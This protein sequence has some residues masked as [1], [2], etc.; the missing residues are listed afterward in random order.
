MRG[1]RIPRARY[2]LSVAAALALALAACGGDDSSSSDGATSAAADAA[3]TAAAAGESSAAAASG[4]KVNLT[5]W[6]WGD[7]DAP[8]ANGW[9][10]AAVTAY[11]AKNPN[12]T[13]EVVEQ[14]TDTFIATFQAAAAAKSGP[15]I[16][17]Q[18]ATG[19]VLTQ[20]WGGAVTAIS[21]LVPA[22]ETAHWL[23]TSENTYDG[24]V[25]A[26]PLYLIGIP[27]VSNKD[28][29][30][31]A[32]ITAPPATWDELISACTALRAKDITP[33]AFGNDTYWM[34][35]LVLQSVQSVDDVIQASV[36]NKKYTDPELAAF[37]GALQQ[38]VEA[39]CFNED[40]GSVGLAKGQEQFAAG[41]AAMTLGTDGSVRQWAKDLGAEK[42]IV[43]KWPTYGTGPMKDTYNATQSTSY[44]VTSWSEHQQEAA[45]FLQFLHSPE[46]LDAWYTATGTPPADD[47]FDTAKITDPLDQQ[48][49]GF[50]TTGPQVWLQNFFPPQVDLN[51]NAPAQQLILGGDGD[52]AAAAEIRER[53]AA[54]WRAQKPDELANWAA[55]KVGG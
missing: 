53:A 44:F 47:R 9:L 50:N 2:G 37:G 6:F 40:V 11:Q 29:L 36:G 14:A 39:K 12:V 21:D 18:W 27:W 7:A 55:F 34:T 48:L 35:Q 49:Y 43:S 52:A 32:G 38:M 46:M 51:G 25:W 54:Q 24:K 23:N 30:A 8:G 19:P 3:T 28:L 4:E 22:E 13:V 33:F 45:A 41:T 16:A 42:I 26:M 31:Q 15:D 20:V 17:A 10:D 5:M 1:I